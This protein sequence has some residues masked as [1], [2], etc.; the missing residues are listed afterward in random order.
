MTKKLLLKILSNPKN[1]SVKQF[2]TLLKHYGYIKKR[3]RGSHAL[4]ENEIIK[5]IF[6]FPHSR[7]V[8]KCYIKNFL[9][10]INET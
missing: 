3:Q 10:T 7:P 6:V 9:K 1:V 4:Y 5:D 2:E 8:K